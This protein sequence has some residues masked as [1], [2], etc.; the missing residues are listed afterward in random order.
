MLQGE[1]GLIWP[2]AVKWF[3]KSS[4]TTNDKSKF[5]PVSKEILWKC[6]YKGGF[7]A[8]AL[9]LG[10][11]PSSNFFSRKGLILGGSH[12]PVALNQHAHCGDLS[13]VLLQQLNPLVN[14]VRVPP[15]GLSLWTNGKVKL[16]RS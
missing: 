13:A 9:Y 10:N 16:K 8:V 2:T 11:N 1:Q 3:A 7:D 5:L 15:S 6:H 4:G 12:K 14:L